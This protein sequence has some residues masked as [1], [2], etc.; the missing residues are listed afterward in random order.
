MPVNEFEKQVQQ[1]MDELQL[2]PSEAIWE[3]VEKR[4]HKERKRRRFIIWFFIFGALLLVGTGWWIAADTN[5]Q[6]AINNMVAQQV[7][8]KTTNKIIAAKKDTIVNEKGLQNQA[9][10]DKNKK[11]E[12]LN[13]KP[14]TISINERA[15]TSEVVKLYNKE[16]AVEYQQ[17]GKI[18]NKKS[19]M[20]KVD[21]YKNI[22]VYERVLAEKSDKLNSSI[23]TVPIIHR[24]VQS[25][26]KDSEIGNAAIDKNILQITKAEKQNKTDPEIKDNLLL[27]ETE[28]VSKKNTDTAKK[29]KWEF[30][31]TGSVGISGLSHGLSFFGTEKS[32]DAANSQ[33][34]TSGNP[35]R[36]AVSAAEPRKGFSW[37]LGIYAKRKLTERIWLSTGVNV[38]SYSTIQ[39]AGV[40]V[41]SL[42][43]FSTTFNQSSVRNFYRNGSSISYTNHYYYLQVPFYFHWQLTKG[44]KFPL[45]LQ[46]GFS[47]GLLAGSDAL[48]YN[49]V[50][51]VFYRDNKLLNK[52]QLSYQT[53]LYTNPFKQSKKSITAGIFFNYQ[54][55]KL[56]KVNI[57]GSNHLSTFG[58]QLGWNFKK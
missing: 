8:D 45:L 27:K 41:D 6:S 26:N 42:R 35:G 31:A 24:D 19:I 46:N 29:K 32:L 21:S 47:L 17:P 25:G 20:E 30:G 18:R 1:K 49:T 54:L 22:T 4:I 52:A 51:N 57:N 34:N 11:E 14:V 38:A 43:I 10:D 37:Q 23:I 33:T 12:I 36:I 56:Q 3:E 7:S 58:I 44:N 9:A 5:K 40:F 15:Q 53:G 55:S 50:S 48:V 39:Q 28:T 2:R 16:K 13:T